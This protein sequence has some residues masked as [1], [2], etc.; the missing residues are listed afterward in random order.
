MLKPKD[1]PKAYAKYLS[2]DKVLGVLTAHK[3]EK[4]GDETTPQRWVFK[5]TLNKDGTPV[6]LTVIVPLTKNANFAVD[7]ERCEPPILEVGF[8]FYASGKYCS[9]EQCLTPAMLDKYL[10]AIERG[11]IQYRRKID[12]L[13]QAAENTLRA[14]A[15][16]VWN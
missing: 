1:R 2:V 15:E 13:G 10:K 3:F 5:R 12:L 16:L 8:P 4:R 7:P 6:L 9:E 14:L 11:V